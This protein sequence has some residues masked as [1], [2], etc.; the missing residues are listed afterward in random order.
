MSFP[1]RAGAPREQGQC[2]AA[3]APWLAPRC[4]TKEPRLQTAV[5]SVPPPLNGWRA[6][7]A[8]SPWACSQKGVPRGSFQ[9]EDRE[10]FLSLKPSV[11]RTG[12][13][14]DGCA[15]WRWRWTE[16]GSL[17]YSLA[18]C[19]TAYATSLSPSSFIYRMGMI[20]PTSLSVGSPE[21]SISMKWLS[22]WREKPG[23][24]RCCSN[25]VRRGLHEKA[26]GGFSAPLLIW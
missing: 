24:N 20:M 5:I 16:R 23:E 19:Q 15:P 6:P 26:R 3:C 9:F 10:T 21:K 8:S 22:L 12:C 18:V 7:G 14:L 13:L 1:S 4:Q 2:K 17:Q 11:S 25:G